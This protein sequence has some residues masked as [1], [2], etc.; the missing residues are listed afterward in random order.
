M[1]TT[2]RRRPSD[3][4]AATLTRPGDFSNTTAREPRQLAHDDGTDRVG[5]IM[6]DPIPAHLCDGGRTRTVWLRPVGGGCE[7]PAERRNVRIIG[8]DA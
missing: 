8:G 5:E 4:A 1:T 7:W 6:P 3:A 2:S